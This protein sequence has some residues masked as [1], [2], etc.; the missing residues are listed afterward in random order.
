MILTFAKADASLTARIN[1]ITNKI[2][3]ILGVEGGAG[4]VLTH[5]AS[6]TINFNELAFVDKTV[7]VSGSSFGHDELTTITGNV[8]E[9]H[10]GAI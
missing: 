3:T 2:A 6:S 9:T 10:S 7:E 4:L 5:S 1:A 8:T